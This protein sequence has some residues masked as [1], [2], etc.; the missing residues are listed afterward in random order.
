M[1]S[2]WAAGIVLALTVG[3]AAGLGG[4]TFVY[5]KG[6]SSMTN[7]PAACNNCHVMNEHYDGWVRSTHHAVATCN[8]CHAPANL[9]G[10]YMTKATNGF[11]HSFAF[12]TGLFP[13]PLLI[14]GVNRE[15]A[16]K[17]CRKCHADLVDA[18]DGGHGGASEVSCIRCH[19]AVGHPTLATSSGGRPR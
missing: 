17:S 8:D 9:V 19:G 10:T 11:W 3:L 18:M 16:E 5:A 14:R 13:D 2:T 15:I 7:D 4:S 12:T 1:K 6:Y